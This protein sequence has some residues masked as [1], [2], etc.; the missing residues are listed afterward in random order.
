MADGNLK[1]TSADIRAA[2]RLR[3]EATSHALLFEVADGTGANAK[4]YADAVAVGLWPSHGHKI[5]GVEIKVS[6]SD[7]LREL[8]DHSKAE[9]VYRYCNHWWI[10]CPKGMVSPDELPP[11]WGLLEL[12]GES[13]RV[14]VKAPLLT[15]AAPAIGFVAAMLR[16]HAG[17]DEEMVRVELGR[18]EASIRKQIEEQL[19]REYN[20]RFQ[21][22]IEAAKRA[23]DQWEKVKAETGIDLTQYSEG[24]E[25]IAAVSVVR[26]LTNG[27]QAPLENLLK[28]ARD[29][30]AVLEQNGFASSNEPGQKGSAWEGVGNGR[31]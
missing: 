3:F 30:V 17:A 13:L 28:G 6:R 12:V 19:R 14:K 22:D 15:P 5:E 11:T 4:R 16:R 10:A 21:S 9:A 29:V 1:V 8:K 2:L 23:R 25:F 26:Q 18:R 24:A 27:W 20:N 7:F 31:G